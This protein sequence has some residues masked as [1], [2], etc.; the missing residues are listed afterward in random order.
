MRLPQ[1]I[2]DNTELIVGEWET[3]A[4]SL[5][6]ASDHMGPLALRNH[7]HQ[8]LAFVTADIE[9]AQTDAEQVR[10]SHGEKPESLYPSAA[11]VHASLRFDGGFNMDQMVSEY[12]SLRASVI[13][14]WQAAAPE[15]GPEDMRDLIRFNE[16]IDQ[17][18]TESICDYTKKMDL[19]RNLFLGILSHDLRNPLGAISMS[20]QLTMKI[21][22]LSER[23]TMLQ[24]QISDS[25]FRAT[26]IVSSLLDLTRARLG[27]G[28]PILREAMDIGFI[29]NQL[30]DEMRVLHPNRDFVLTV[31]GDTTGDWDKAR[32]GQVFSNLLGNAVQYGF[33][34]APITIRVE[35]MP[36]EVVLSVHN[37]G[38]PI[39]E[40]AIGTIFNA[41]TRA[42][43]PV[44][45]TQRTPLTN[46]GLGLYIS[47]E[48]VTAHGG[49]IWV[50]SSEREGTTFTAAFPRTVKTPD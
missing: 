6:P 19:S 17:A 46:L 42:P 50:T 4:R 2:R 9:S 32:I 23:Q 38:V 26:A 49:K 29:S 33:R 34:G 40:D 1:F 20:A 25:S 10:K 18:L 39:S 44:D 21:G 37:E 7:I 28:L 22:A 27:S 3:F 16:A 11:E 13:K 5:V 15:S 45:D 41:L 8:I 48:I 36:R 14:L 24:S 12:R 47:K 31:S 30:V 43:A 35:G